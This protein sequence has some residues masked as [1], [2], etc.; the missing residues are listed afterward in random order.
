MLVV[1]LNLKYL[2]MLFLNRVTQILL[3]SGRLLA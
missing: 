1:E 3:Y 2:E